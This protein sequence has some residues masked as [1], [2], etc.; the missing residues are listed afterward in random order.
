[1]LRSL[2][3]I[4]E[5][6]TH[7]FV[8]LRDLKSQGLGRNVARVGRSRQF[9]D[10]RAAYTLRLQLGTGLHFVYFNYIYCNVAEQPDNNLH[11][12][13]PSREHNTEQIQKAVEGFSVCHD[14]L[15]SPTIFRTAVQSMTLVNLLTCGIGS[16]GDTYT[17]NC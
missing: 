3:L 1:M 9:V 2:F 12:N 8:F 11:L 17:L 13:L 6:L 15:L 14:H 7:I 16:R 4:L 5:A 10:T